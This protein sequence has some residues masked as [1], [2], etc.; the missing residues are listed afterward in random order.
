MTERNI[1]L[2]RISVQEFA[3][4]YEQ[5]KWT[6]GALWIVLG[7]LGGALAGFMFSPL[8]D[9]PWWLL[10]AYVAAVYAFKRATTRLAQW[11]FAPDFWWQVT[12]VFLTTFVLTCLVCA[13]WLL[14]S[15]LW[16]GLPVIIAASLV[17]AF[18]HNISRVLFV[19]QQFAWWYLAP[20]FA[21]VATSTGWLLL[22]T[23]TLDA[24]NPAAT[25]I[26]GAV[27]GFL[28]PCLTTILLRLMWD[29]SFA[30]SRHGTS[31]V[32]KHEEFEEGLALQRAA[33]AFE[34][35]N[36]K[37][38]TA[39]AETYH[40]QGKTD[41]AQEDIEQALALD[42]QCAEARVLRAVLMAEEDHIDEAIAEYDQFVNYKSGFYPAYLNRAR[43]Y[44]QKGDFDRAFDDYVR[45]QQLGEDSAL[46]LA[47]RAQTHFLLGNYEYAINDCNHVIANQTMT[48][49]AYAMV[50]ITRGKCYVAMG[51]DER[52]FNDLWSGI[53]RTT[54]PVV[55]TEGEKGLRLLSDESLQEY[56]ANLNSQ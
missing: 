49:F 56:F 9:S 50:L 40:K 41:R 3:T 13:V 1:V 24:A 17:I 43:A 39:R 32:D 27:I 25:A 31:Y 28:Y 8:F 16:I 14:T 4:L 33:I 5:L 36:P 48:C 51:E 47:Y 34:P 22:W 30:L 26:V 20:L 7:T 2:K 21:P 15:S 11:Y 52:G 35:H 19:R 29:V 23:H 46:A 12:S 55:V 44:A 6:I 45:A 42:P 10:P 53:E 38:Y 37:L 54:L 18:F